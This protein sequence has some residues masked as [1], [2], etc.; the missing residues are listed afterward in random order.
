MALRTIKN[1]NHGLIRTV[2]V[3]VAALVLF[4]CDKED[5]TDNNKVTI[6]PVIKSSVEPVRTRALA[7]TYTE[8]QG[9]DRQALTV[10]AIA[11]KLD[12]DAQNIEENYNTRAQDYDK[13]GVFAPATTGWRS[14]VEAENGYRYNLYAYSRT[15]PTATTPVFS[16]V[17][18]SEITLTFNGL[19]LITTDDPLVCVA[20]RGAVLQDN[21]DPNLYP[22]L[23]NGVFNIGII[24]GVGQS[25]TSTK[26]FLAMN[27]LYS[28]ATLKFK[29]D[30][31]YS[32][33][34][35]I[36]IKNVEIKTDK[37]T[38][39]GSHVYSFQNQ[40]FTLA[41]NGG[42]T[43]TGSPETIDLYS[44]PTALPT[45]KEGDSCVVLNKDEYIPF[46]YFY[47]LPKYPLPSMYLEVTYDICEL[48][49]GSTVRHNEKAMNSH[50][51]DAIT[52]G[53]NRA[54]AGTNYNINIKVDPTYIYQLSDNDMERGLI[55]AQE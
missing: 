45:T 51:F 15:M 39:P 7:G 3:A 55:V 9:T 17:S 46:G 27:H 48:V 23:T 38:Y 37:N 35:S 1:N 28:K 20:A 12:Q 32:T 19:D 52:Y 22:D 11:F 30:S 8:L 44:G 2:A 24:S 42:S 21:P 49:D 40:S 53:T 10:Q 26:A 16:F 43:V 4:G 33:I 29:V 13:Q 14:T 36:K 31:A 41:G 50:L 54:K 47:F 5:L 6:Y 18:E 34:R 25:G